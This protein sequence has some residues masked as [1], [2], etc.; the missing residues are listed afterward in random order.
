MVLHNKLAEVWTNQL[1]GFYLKIIRLDNK[2]TTG[3]HG[4]FNS[5]DWNFWRFLIFDFIYIA[6]ELV[7][8]KVFDRPHHQGI[9]PNGQEVAVKRL[10]RSS[11]Q[12]TD[13]FIN[14]VKVIAKLQHR[15]LVK[16]LGFCLEGEEKILIYEFVR[17][18]SLDCFLFG[19]SLIY[20]IFMINLL[21]SFYKKC[22]IFV[23]V[24]FNFYSIHG[25]L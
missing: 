19:K 18:K 25:I 13:E 11:G 23:R 20:S 16:L 24:N 1:P 14:E 22:M 10:S 6:S 15:N 4:G 7:T 12:G 8:I 9:F 2:H 5:S 21:I 17:N 3:W